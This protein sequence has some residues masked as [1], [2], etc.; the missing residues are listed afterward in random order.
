MKIISWNIR[1]LNSPHKHNLVKNMIRD[2]NPDIFLIQETKM[3]KDKV[4]SLNM[5]KN[6][7]VSGGSSEGASGG[8]VT[9]WNKNNVEGEVLIQE[10]NLVCIRFKHINNCTTWV[11]TNV[12]APN[13]KTGRSEM[14]RYLTRL[15]SRFAEDSWIIMGDFNTPLKKNEK[16]GGSQANLDSRLDLMDFIN[17][18]AI[19]DLELQGVKYTWTN[20]RSGENLI[21]V[22]LDRALLSLDWF[23]LH[24][25]S[26]SSHIRARVDHYPITFTAEVKN[27][28][29]HFPY[30]FEKMWT[31]H[32]DLE[33]KI[34]DW[35][36]VSIE[37]NAMYKVVKKLKNV[38]DNVKKWNKDCF[39]NIFTSKATTLL[40]LKEIQDEI[41]NNGCTN[42]SR[43]TEDATLMRYHDIIAKEETYQ[44][45]RSRNVWLK[46]GD[47][48]TKYF[49]ISTLRHKAINR[50]VQI[51]VNSRCVVEDDSMRKVAMDFFS[52]LLAKD[53][54]LNIQAQSK[55]LDSIPTILGDDQNDHLT[56]I[57]SHDEILIAINS[58][59]GNK[60]PGPDGFLMFFFQMYQHIIG[61]D[62]TRAVKEFFGARKLLK[63]V[64]GTFIALIPK[65]MGV[66]SMDLFRPISL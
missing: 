16:K 21:Q 61:D 7:G 58:F 42:M 10:N 15:R 24:E 31:R 55:L 66:D 35:W 22:R 32:L 2:K 3:A 63:E 43:D 9:F 49:H 25:C 57:P 28:R 20:R 45:Q 41:Q 19:H 33:S 26:L 60:A 51:K 1:G 64:N 27:R 14:W 8:I 50:I 38:K 59:E 6:G 46:E 40:E 34:K 53:Q 52:N 18:N 44:K 23:N 36:Q 17:N 12:Y 39:G 37:G 13:T 11:L 65:K 48:N 62:V 4:E 30:R 56:A 47:S 54:N 5:F 29:R